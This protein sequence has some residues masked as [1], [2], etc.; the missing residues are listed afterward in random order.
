MTTIGMLL[1]DRL[2]QLDL[3][4]PYEVFARLPDARVV[5]VSPSG[6]PVKSEHGRM[7]A[8]FVGPFGPRCQWPV[9]PAR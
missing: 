5:L 8:C 7:N 1:F 3:T 4:G 2:T 6:G 9:G